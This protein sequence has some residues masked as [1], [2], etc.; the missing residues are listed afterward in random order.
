[1]AGR[2]DRRRGLQDRRTEADQ[3][4]SKSL[5]HPEEYLAD[6]YG[7]YARGSRGEKQFRF[8]RAIVV[9]AR[10]WRKLANE[11]L[12]TIG[13]SQARWETLFLIALSGGARPLTDLAKLISIEG[14]TLVRMLDILSQEGLIQRETSARDGR[15][16]VNR[17]TPAGAGAVQQIKGV[18]DG[19]R[20]EVLAVLTDEEMQVCHGALVKLIQALEAVDRS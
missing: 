8:T 6:Y 5:S 14:P 20:E 13:Q 4:A 12:K 2:A 19:L 11:R 9:A 17:L 10:L 1:M 3:S 15:V 18:T 7:H 16:K